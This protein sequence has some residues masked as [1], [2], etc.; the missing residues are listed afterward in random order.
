MKL[1]FSAEDI[2]FPVLVGIDGD[3]VT[4]LI[5]GGQPVPAPILASAVLDTGTNITVLSASIARR[6]NLEVVTQRPTRT[7]AGPAEADIYMISVGFPPVFGLPATAT[8]HDKVFVAV[9]PDMDPDV[10]VLFGLDLLLRCR[11][12]IDG[13]GRT[14]ALDF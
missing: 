2:R 14:F 5:D 10:D 8:L 1:P 6:L 9:L 7:A 3:W 12:S 13:P 11:V 4:R